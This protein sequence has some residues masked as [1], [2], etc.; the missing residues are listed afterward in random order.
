MNCEG[1]EAIK[2]RLSEENAKKGAK[3]PGEKTKMRGSTRQYD[4]KENERK[5]KRNQQ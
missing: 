5:K 4:K 1:G 3:T 2:F